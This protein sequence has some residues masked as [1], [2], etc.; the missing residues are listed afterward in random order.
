MILQEFQTPNGLME[1]LKTRI[2]LKRKM[3]TMVICNKPTTDKLQVGDNTTICADIMN[4][5]MAGDPHPLDKYCTFLIH[6]VYTEILALLL[7][8]LPFRKEGLLDCN[9]CV[10]YLAMAYA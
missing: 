1:A 2:V 4:Y 10:S 8:L 3:H 5:V 7:S 9:F 6:L